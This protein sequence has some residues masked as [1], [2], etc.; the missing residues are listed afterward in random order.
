[1]AF[2]E[3]TDATLDW[4]NIKPPLNNVQSEVLKGNPLYTKG[5]DEDKQCEILSWIFWKPMQKAWGWAESMQW[6]TH[7][8]SATNLTT[9]HSK[10][11]AKEENLCTW[12]AS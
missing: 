12:C 8:V 7:F 5:V 4:T 2:P 3:H 6:T 10:Q 9:Q 1:M 11:Y